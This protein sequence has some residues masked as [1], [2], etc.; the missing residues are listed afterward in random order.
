MGA[1]SVTSNTS[2]VWYRPRIPA[3]RTSTCYLLTPHGRSPTFIPHVAL[4]GSN[5]PLPHAPG[6]V[7]PIS[8]SPGLSSLI[9][10]LTEGMMER[11]GLAMVT[12]VATGAF[13]VCSRFSPTASHQSSA[14]IVRQVQVVSEW[15]CVA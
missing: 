6:D 13:P 3:L 9:L 2:G 5:E 4:Q 12:V 8:F 11:W 10:P 1:G 15:A 7:E 14:C